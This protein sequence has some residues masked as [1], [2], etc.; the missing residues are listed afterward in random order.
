MS[1]ASTL[2]AAAE[3]ARLL[4]FNV[5][6]AL[7]RAMMRDGYSPASNEF[8]VNY[9]GAHYVGQLAGRLGITGERV[10]FA[11]RGKW[12]AVRFV[13][14]EVVDDETLL[15]PV[16][17]PESE[18]HGPLVPAGWRISNGYDAEYLL[19]PRGRAGTRAVHTG[20]D[21]VAGAGT[22]GAPVYAVA[23]GEV[24]AAATC[25][26]SWGQVIT[27]NH[28]NL[29]GIGAVESQYAHLSDVAVAVGARVEQGQ[30]IGAVGDGDGHF[31]PHLHFELRR[32]STAACYWPSGGGRSLATAHD[33]VRAQYIAP[34]GWLGR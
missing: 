30:R 1:L 8:P 33:I 13:P 14:R 25:G 11:E 6:A 27:I 18:R 2:R 10:Y 31:A 23:A 22:Y 12:D 4:R 29:P 21:L 19:S 28:G 20:L 3:S 17:S 5:T 15:W 7:E 24:T 9:K 32:P 16:G 34:L 26:G